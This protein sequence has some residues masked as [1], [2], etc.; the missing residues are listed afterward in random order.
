[1][2]ESAGYTINRLLAQQN[3]PERFYDSTMLHS[4]GTYLFRARLELLHKSLWAVWQALLSSITRSAGP[5]A[6]RLTTNQEIAGSIPASIK[7]VSSLRKYLFCWIFGRQASS[8][9]KLVLSF[10]F[11]RDL[12]LF[13]ME[14]KPLFAQYAKFTMVTISV[15]KQ[16]KLREEKIVHSSCHPHSCDMSPISTPPYSTEMPLAEL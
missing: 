9:P 6:R 1:M 4:G 11:A 3:I 14:G 12:R 7:M 2:A 16:F 13:D 15:A 8:S 5:M 10:L